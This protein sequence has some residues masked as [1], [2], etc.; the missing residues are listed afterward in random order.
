MTPSPFDTV[1][2][3]I[4]AA[5]AAAANTPH[6]PTVPLLL[7]ILAGIGSG[8][9]ALHAERLPN[10]LRLPL[11]LLGVVC[12]IGVLVLEPFLHAPRQAAEAAFASALAAAPACPTQD[13]LRRTGIAAADLRA[14][15]NPPPA[16]AG[17]GSATFDPS[18]WGLGCPHIVL[19]PAAA[20]SLPTAE[21]HIP[22]AAFASDADIRTMDEAELAEQM[23][24]SRSD[25][26]FT[27][28]ISAAL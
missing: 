13:Q 22:A 3:A 17:G 20:A 28:T 21:G 14:F 1:Q 27:A 6:V 25:L 5:H 10:R 19:L 15:L 9:L 16:R 8:F 11:G 24:R 12:M 18:G 23:R 26:N 2:A 4:E 7:L